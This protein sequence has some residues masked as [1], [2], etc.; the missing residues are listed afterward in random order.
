MLARNTEFYKINL[1]V[2]TDHENTVRPPVC[3][4]SMTSS[5]D[6]LSKVKTFVQNHRLDSLEGKNYSLIEVINP[7]PPR[8]S[9]LILSG[10]RQSKIT[11]WTVLAG[12]GEKGLIKEITYAEWPTVK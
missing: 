11:K 5:V 9:P 6:N 4:L 3:S 7:F 2:V 1:S 10:V 8:G 12:M